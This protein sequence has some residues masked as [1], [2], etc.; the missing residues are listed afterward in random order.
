MSRSVE[1]DHHAAVRLSAATR[2]E[3][4][5]IGRF[6]GCWPDNVRVT[7]GPRAIR[8]ADRF[9]VRRWLR[10]HGRDVHERRTVP[11]RGHAANECDQ[12]TDWR[13]DVADA[14]ADK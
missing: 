12:S 7:S 13:L 4:N 8:S 10:Q 11:R 2:H 5:F 3:R 1:N 14:T 9:L 6:Y